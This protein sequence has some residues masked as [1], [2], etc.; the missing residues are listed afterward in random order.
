MSISKEQIFAMLFESIDEINKQ[1]D[2]AQWLSRT[3]ESVILGAENESGLD[4]VAFL[5]FVALIEEKFEQRFG[6]TIV[7]S[8]DRGDANNSF[9]TVDALAAHIENM[10]AR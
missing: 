1:L 6:K 5:N 9:A 10:M 3:P 2:R 7:L 4:S 8:G